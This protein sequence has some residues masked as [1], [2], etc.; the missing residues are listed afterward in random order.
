MDEGNHTVLEIVLISGYKSLL[1]G[2]DN[3]EEPRG[4]D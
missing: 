3:S 4:E 1:K 2:N